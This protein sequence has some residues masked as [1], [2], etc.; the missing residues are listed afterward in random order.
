MDEMEDISRALS[1]GRAPGTVSTSEEEQQELEAELCALMQEADAGAAA[2][3]AHNA[4]NKGGQRVH[5][6][7]PAVPMSKISGSGMARSIGSAE[8][9]EGNK[10]E[11]V[12]A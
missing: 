1:G 10:K 8:Q 6:P 4:S 5:E 11:K 3:E 2:V 9:K 12:L 7:L